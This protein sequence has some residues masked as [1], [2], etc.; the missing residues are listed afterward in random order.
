[1]AATETRRATEL[2]EPSRF[3]VMDFAGDADAE[4]RAVERGEVL[5]R[6]MDGPGAG[7]G[8][9]DVP[10]A[11]V[12]HW[13]GAVF[14]PGMTTESLM[15]ALRA[16]PPPQ[17]DVLR[18][19]VLARDDSSMSVYLRLRR[20]RFVTVVYDT[21]HQVTFERLGRDRAAST[22]V[23]TRITE[24]DNPGSADERALSAGEDHGFLWRLNAYWRYQEVDGGV[25]AECESLTLSR[26][27]PFGLAAIAGPLIR[28]T[29]RESMAAALR[30]VA[31]LSD[32]AEL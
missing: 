19:R 31:G 24:I 15:A 4:R 8:V 11:L 10:S 25:I 17:E 12:H 9:M 18:A 6:Q 32:G 2:R 1:V 13:R 20:T 22:S 30:A 7:R 23:A 21:E 27:I 3:L 16:G 5:V 14:V 28:S 26:S 29:A